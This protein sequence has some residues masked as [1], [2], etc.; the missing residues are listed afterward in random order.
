MVFGVSIKLSTRRKVE[1]PGLR[2]TDEALTCAGW[3]LVWP[4]FR[5]P[6][7]AR[8]ANGTPLNF[9]NLA[10]RVVR[11]ALVKAGLKWHRWHSFRR[12]LATNLHR[13]G[14]PDK[15]IQ[16]ILRN[17]DLSTTMNSYVK[18]VSADTMAAMHSLERLCTEYAPN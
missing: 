4:E 7:Q 2:Q 10:R 17:A 3:R 9:A 18:T 6:R 14:V 12:G 15:T 5:I 16:A 8:Q 11:P 13:L 1:S